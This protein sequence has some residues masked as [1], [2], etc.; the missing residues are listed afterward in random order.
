MRWLVV[1]EGKLRQAP[2]RALC[3][4]YLKRLRR[5][6]RTEMIEVRGA[7]RLRAAVPAD[8][9]SVAVTP[10]GS[11]WSSAEVARRLARWKLEGRDVAFVVGGA[12]GLPRSLVD[13]AEARWSLSPLTLPHELARVL[14]L[15]QL[16]RAESILKGEPYHRGD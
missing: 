10:D 12:D 3:D 7:D 11:G 15:E 8:A 5:Y 6:T 13:E 9:R 4:D 16:Y 14:V 2:S 1:A